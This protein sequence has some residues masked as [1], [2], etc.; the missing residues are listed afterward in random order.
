MKRSYN[1]IMFDWDANKAE[2]NLAKH[3]VAFEAAEGFDFVT[4]IIWPDD[5]ADYDEPRWVAVG[6]I[7]SRL[8]VLVYTVRKGRTRIISLRRAN[9]RE[10]RDYDQA[11]A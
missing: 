6:F 4:S 7:G 5:R 9:S 3:G 2:A 8:H 11:K 1:L 10:K